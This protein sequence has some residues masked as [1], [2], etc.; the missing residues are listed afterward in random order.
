VTEPGDEDPTVEVNHEQLA[1][2]Q[3]VNREEF[4]EGQ[5]QNGA[6]FVEG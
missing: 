2:R 3:N 6:T 5:P 1:E 4:A